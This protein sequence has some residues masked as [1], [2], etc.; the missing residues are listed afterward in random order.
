MA[1]ICIMVLNQVVLASGS[2]FFVNDENRLSTAGITSFVTKKSFLT[3]LLVQWR[4]LAPMIYYVD[5]IT[6]ARSEWPLL[7]R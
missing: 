2:G 6:L 1:P 5:A 7:W 4:G 3:W